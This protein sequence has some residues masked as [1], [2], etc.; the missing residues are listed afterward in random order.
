VYLLGPTVKA[1]GFSTLLT[2]MAVISGFTTLFVALLPGRIT[3]PAVAPLVAAT[4]PRR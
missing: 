2:V 3:A 1:A 4:S